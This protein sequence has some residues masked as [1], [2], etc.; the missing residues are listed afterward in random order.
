M[1]QCVREGVCG[2]VC[3]GGC[4]WLMLCVCGSVCE[5]GCVCVAQCVREGV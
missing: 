2:S 5:G 3:E 4:V 1:A